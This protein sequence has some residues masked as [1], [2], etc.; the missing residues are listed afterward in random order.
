M[1]MDITTQNKLSQTIYRGIAMKVMIRGIQTV[2]QIMNL[3]QKIHIIMVT[4]KAIWM[5]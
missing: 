2:S 4:K 5:E 3:L 1:K